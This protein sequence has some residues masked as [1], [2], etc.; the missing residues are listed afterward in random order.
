M[1]SPLH[2]PN[3]ATCNSCGAEIVWARTSA[4]KL[5]P[6]D[7]APTPGGNIVFEDDGTVRY[8]RKDQKHDGDTYASHF[9]TCPNAASHRKG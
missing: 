7:D 9:S 8:L 4:G 5:A 3:I 6:I 2:D 1:S